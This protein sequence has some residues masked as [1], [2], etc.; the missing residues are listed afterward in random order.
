MNKEVES[1]PLERITERI[2]LVRG[3]KVI[4]DSDLAAFYGVTTKA[5]NQAVKRNRDRF[6]ADFMFQLTREEKAEVVTNCDHLSSLKYSPHL[7]HAFTE[8]GA[9]MAASVLNSRRATEISVF[10]VRA[11]L[12]LRQAVAGHRELARKLDELEHK[13][14]HHDQQIHAIVQAIRQL[15]S[16]ASLPKKRRIGFI[17][18]PDAKE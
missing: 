6:P 10:I 4:L 16:P 9:I 5:F 13:L 17:S 15:T 18:G 11:F 7:P 2:L 14:T 12:Q 1:V 3:E 8:H